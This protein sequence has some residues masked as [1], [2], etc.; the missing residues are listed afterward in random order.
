MSGMFLCMDGLDGAG[1]STQLARLADWLHQQGETVE[2]CRDPGSTRA[3]ERIRELL[4]DPEAHIDTT[5]EMLLYMASRA[6]LVDE[7][8]APALA[9]GKVV[10]CDRFLTSTLVYQGYGGGQDLETIRQVGMIATKGHLPDWTVI[11]DLPAKVAAAR[12]TVPADRIESRAVEYH[13]AVR[14]GFLSEARRDPERFFVV[15][16]TGDAD[17]I[18]RQ[19]TEEVTRVLAR[20]RRS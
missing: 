17:S 6:Q 12:R 11:L 15:D 4:L 14:Q 16:G 20:T 10:L 5:A 18:H 7:V 8:I 9:D 13:E 19:I 1:K 3:S 2:R